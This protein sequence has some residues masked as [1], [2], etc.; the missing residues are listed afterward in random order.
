M[1]HGRFQ[2]HILV[3]KHGRFQVHIL[4]DVPVNVG[5]EYFAQLNTIHNKRQRER[6]DV[7]FVNKFSASAELHL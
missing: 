3:V 7:K 6:L 2:V 1:K 5:N 4:V